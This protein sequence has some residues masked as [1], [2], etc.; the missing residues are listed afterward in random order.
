M[1]L[2]PGDK[3]LDLGQIGRFPD[4]NFERTSRLGESKTR[5]TDI[6]SLSQNRIEFFYPMASSNC[7]FAIDTFQSV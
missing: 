2:G 5:A 3:P 6:Y 1:G 7:G 4:Q